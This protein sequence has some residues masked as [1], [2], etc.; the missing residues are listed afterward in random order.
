[1]Y[2][3]RVIESKEERKAA[4]GN[5]AVTELGRKTGQ[6]RERREETG[7]GRLEDLL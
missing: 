4:R 6:A 3:Q 7:R 5:E 1:M 2:E